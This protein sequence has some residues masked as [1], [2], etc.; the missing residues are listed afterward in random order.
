MKKVI[1]YIVFITMILTLP[2]TV[3]FFSIFDSAPFIFSDINFTAN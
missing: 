2:F 3:A 1:L